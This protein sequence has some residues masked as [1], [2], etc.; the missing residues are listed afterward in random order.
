MIASSDQLALSTVFASAQA[1]DSAA[2]AG[3]LLDRLAAS[4]LTRLE[5]E[6]RLTG[7]LA[8]GVLAEFKPRGLSVASVHNFCPLP[9]GVERDQ[10]SGDV[11][12]LAS[13]DKEERLEAVK[14]TIAT[15]ETAHRAEAR[16]V[17]LHMGWAPGLEDKDV[18]RTAARVG[19]M[20]PELQRARATRRAASPAAADA[21][22]FALERLIKR[23]Q[24]LELTMGLEN[25]YHLYQTPDFAE[26][27]LLLE[28][29]AG[30]PLG[31][32]HDTG[33]GW[34]RGRAGLTPPGD[35]LAA[36]GGR[37]AGCHL[38]DA[39]GENDHLPPGQGEMDWEELAGLLLPA[40]LKVM[41]VAPGPEP[42][43]LAPAAEMLARAFA[44]AR[45]R[46][47]KEAKP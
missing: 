24:G 35:W 31:Y 47:D 13:P 21:M 26:T 41:E 17:V 22:S 46:A 42:A 33:H 16:G 29:F 5:L 25:R 32:W 11:L 6:Y 1:E 4:G 9:P 27:G 18:T 45:A 20:T 36:Y 40:P 8:A 38:H 43:E 34:V 14:L 19:E 37:L 3:W 44:T 28:R 23:A 39:V 2:G 15:L 10:A 12:N 7:R 30:A